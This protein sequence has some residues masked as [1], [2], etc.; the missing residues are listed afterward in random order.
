MKPFKEFLTEGLKV[1]SKKELEKG[2]ILTNFDEEAYKEFVKG[3]NNEKD[4]HNPKKTKA[5]DFGWHYKGFK[6]LEAKKGN[7]FDRIDASKNFNIMR[8]RFNKGR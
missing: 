6:A 5:W 1:P 7:E 4:P 3:W 8:K 2:M